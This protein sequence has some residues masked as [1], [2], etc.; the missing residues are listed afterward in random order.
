MLSS[1]Y[2]FSI[3]VILVSVFSSAC[4]EETGLNPNSS[5]E[6]ATQT[7]PAPSIHGEEVSYQA[8]DTTMKGY[9]AYDKARSGA[10]P[11]VLVVH[12]WWGHNDYARKRARMLAELG[13]TALAVDMYGDGKTAGHPDDA[14]KFM[15]EVM[16][17]IE[18]AETR[19]AAARKVLEGHETTD[20]EKTAAI[21]YCFGG[22]VVL[23]LA[24][25]GSDLDGVVSFHGS[26]KGA[27][28]A[29]KG[30]VKAPV[31]VLHGGSDPFV[32][33]ADVVAFKKEMADAG[34]KV[35][36]VAYPE[37]KHAFTNPGATELGEKFGL[38]LEYSEDADKKSW[39]AMKN[40]LA[41]SFR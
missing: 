17:N 30:N 12:E 25:T 41:K 21:G 24:R 5:L 16:S 36:F 23:H 39:A 37:A 33:D 35:E 38:P 28:S 29:K 3:C 10:R 14:K 13:Y 7:I 27:A 32:P 15:M 1:K 31:L 22:G 11:G 4:K 18:G 40:F 26:L 9:L 34:A 19:F 6:V 20:P 8:G 2:R